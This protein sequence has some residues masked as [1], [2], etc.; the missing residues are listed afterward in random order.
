VLQ[1][2]V[3]GPN[4]NV[5]SSPGAPQGVRAAY[6]HPH[7]DDAIAI[8]VADSPDLVAGISPS[9]SSCSAYEDDIGHLVESAR[10]PI[11][12]TIG[13]YYQAHP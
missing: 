13:L 4:D 2:V 7:I 10:G 9:A 12:R 11:G 5:C 8:V 6:N 3:G 1:P